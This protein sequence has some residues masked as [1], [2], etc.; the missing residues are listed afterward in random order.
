[1]TLTSLHTHTLFCDG[2]DDVEALCA[3][4]WEKGFASIGISAHAP[5]EKA[6]FSS[7]WHLPKARLA[8]YLDEVRSAKKR[9]EGKIAVYLGLEV[10][11]IP[12]VMG[13]GDRE[14]REMGLD[15]IIGSV[16]YLLPPGETSFGPEEGFTVDCPLEEFETGLRRY[17]EGD[18]EAMMA[19]YWDAVAEMV[20]AGGFD[21]LGH[22]DLVKKNNRGNKWFSPAGRLYRGKLEALAGPIAASGA[23]VEVNT[24]GLNR[25]STA[26]TY[27]STG[28][29]SLL[30]EKGVP[31]LITGDVHEKGHLGGHYE[32]ARQT[33]FAAGYREQTLFEGR[34][35]G[36]ACWRKDG[37]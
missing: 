14:Y 9:W 35:G 17:F 22:L 34:T 19:A 2:K 30:H 27:P 10:D 28:I 33:L 15:Y 1:M 8:E 21:I 29:L 25:G 36:K 20:R 31:A 12:G 3:V 13:P 16:H 5:I 24:G 18:G 32:T 23:V 7:G 11:F 26:E 4:A 37:L 6:G